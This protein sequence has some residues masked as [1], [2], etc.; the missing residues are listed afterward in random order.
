MGPACQSTDSDPYAIT[1]PAMDVGTKL[2]MVDISDIGKSACV[3]F[4]DASLMRKTVGI[5]SDL[6][7]GQEIA[8]VFS[9]VVA[10]QLLTM[11]YLGKCMPPLDSLLN[12]SRRISKRAMTLWRRWEVLPC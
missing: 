10:S 5:K 7:T 1:L 4:Q 2:P 9:K 3:I 8:D 6:L 12:P 11:L